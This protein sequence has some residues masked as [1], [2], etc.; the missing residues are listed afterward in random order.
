MKESLW[1]IIK[2][3]YKHILRPLVLKAIDDPESEVDDFV[4]RL[5]DNLFEYDMEE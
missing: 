3:V 1:T 5:L 2:M 4:M